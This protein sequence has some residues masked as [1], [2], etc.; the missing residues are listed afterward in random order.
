MTMILV[1]GGGGGQPGSQTDSQSSRQP[2]A[3]ASFSSQLPTN[4][5]LST[6]VMQLTQISA[7]KISKQKRRKKF[8]EIM[9][10]QIVLVK[11]VTESDGQNTG[12]SGAIFGTHQ[13]SSSSSSSSS[14][15]LACSNLTFLFHL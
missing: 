2:A 9:A 12:R 13:P 6:L 15:F 11:S 1:G 7:S 3:A 5:Q 4:F 10:Q 14:F 8:M